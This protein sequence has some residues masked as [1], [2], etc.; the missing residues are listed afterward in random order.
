MH[1]VLHILGATKILNSCLSTWC[2]FILLFFMKLLK[3][4]SDV[5]R[6]CDEAHLF[7]MGFKW[8]T[9]PWKAG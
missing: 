3:N 9:V 5:I 2:C 8:S 4:Q 1:V 6:A 7:I